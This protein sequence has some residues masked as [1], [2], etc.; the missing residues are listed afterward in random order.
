MS[1]KPRTIGLLGL[2]AALM[3]GLGYV[4]FQDDPVPV[5]L[6]VLTR[7]PLEV[8][9]NADGVTRIKEIYDVASPITGTAL[10]SPVEVGDPA[11]AGETVIAVVR[12]ATPALLD[13]RSLLQAQATVQ[14]AEAALHVAET[15]LARATEERTLARSQ[16]ERTQTL[17]ERDVASLTQLEDAIQRL[18]VAQSTVEAAEARIDMAQSTLNRAET[19]LQVPDAQAQ[20]DASCCVQIMAP[21]DGVILSVAEISERPVVTGAPLL[22][23]GDPSEL[24]IVADLLSS[25]AVRLEIGAPAVVE[26]WGGPQALRAELTR[27]APSAATK[28]SA[29]GIEE[30]RLDA[31][32]DITTPAADRTAL[33]DGFAVFLRITEWHKDDVLQVP[34]S[35]LF[36][37][38]GTWAV[39]TAENGIAT[40]QAI[41]IGRHNTQFAEVLD[42]LAAGMAVV[43]HPNDQ[44]IS[45]GEIVERSALAN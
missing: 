18:A 10:R 38:D 33:G 3:L 4:A 2:G 40:E 11:T 26:R 1:F 5:D 39:F 28:V 8:T 7:G 13:S 16:F 41:R 25:D 22:R 31:I 34:L 12:P 24:E 45:G 35:A 20:A 44:L 30:Q 17:V 29:L 19:M 43:T 14:E 32:F 9:I 36:K 23:L 42:G 21:A 37:T 6:H 27:I 15:D